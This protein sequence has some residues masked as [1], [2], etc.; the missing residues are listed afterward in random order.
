MFVNPEIWPGKFSATTHHM[1]MTEWCKFGNSEIPES[2]PVQKC[3]ICRNPE[4]PFPEPETPFPVSAGPEP[5]PP[6]W[7]GS[8]E[9]PPT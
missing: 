2:V 6:V 4:T 5:D 1:V 7:G 3:A 8:P 9:Y